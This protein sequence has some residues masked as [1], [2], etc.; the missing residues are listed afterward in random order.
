VIETKAL[1]IL[2]VAALRAHKKPVRSPIERLSA[3]RRTL[4]KSRCSKKR[5]KKEKDGKKKKQARRLGKGE[6]QP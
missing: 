3:I 2:R 4:V 6:K 5:K 1:C